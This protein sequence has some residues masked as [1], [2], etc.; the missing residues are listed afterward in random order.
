ME[1]DVL[2]R[3]VGGVDGEDEALLAGEGGAGAEAL[4]SRVSPPLRPA[5]SKSVTTSWPMPLAMTKVSL[6]P[7]PVSTSLPARP[8]R[9]LGLSLPMM[10]LA[11]A[12]PVPAVQEV[13]VMTRFSTLPGK[14]WLESQLPAVP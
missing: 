8:S 6:P 13:P 4:S 9:V 12:L 7:P 3:A 5:P 10:R 1:G 11:S 2:G 14:V